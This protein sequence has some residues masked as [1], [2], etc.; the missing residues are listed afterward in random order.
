MSYDIRDLSNVTR[1][2]YHVRLSPISANVGMRIGALIVLALVP[3]YNIRI[4]AIL[5]YMRKHVL[6]TKYLLYTFIIHL[7]Y[8]RDK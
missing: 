2:T 4:K 5:L 8:T 3:K 7:I 1:I 6:D